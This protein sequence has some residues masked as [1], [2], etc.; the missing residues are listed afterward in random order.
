MKRRRKVEEMRRE[1][2]KYRPV[3]S[4]PSSC[5]SEVARL[6]FFLSLR[7]VSRVRIE[8]KSGERS[9]GGQ[10]GTVQPSE[11]RGRG[12]GETGPASRRGRLPQYEQKKMSNDT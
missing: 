6:S 7:N 2:R 9:K 5:G 10:W 8:D 1:R 4:S 11:G 3:V 12:R